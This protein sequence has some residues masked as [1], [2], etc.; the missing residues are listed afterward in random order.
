MD[1]KNEHVV[2]DGFYEHLITHFNKH[3]DNDFI[4]SRCKHCRKCILHV[5]HMK[6]H[7]Q[8][9]HA[10]NNNSNN[11][12]LQ[13]NS[14]VSMNN[15]SLNSSSSNSSQVSLNVSAADIEIANDHEGS[16]S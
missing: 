7:L 3:E 6:E 14:S 1:E 4:P 11:V 12:K 8:K 9:D 2:V 10:T 13:N 5:R 15:S 16:Y